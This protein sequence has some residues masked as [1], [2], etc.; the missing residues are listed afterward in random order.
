MGSFAELSTAFWRPGPAELLA[1]YAERYRAAMPTMHEAG[2]MTAIS[3]SGFMFP[4]FG[5][6][7]SVR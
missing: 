5:G 4:W 3:V 6:D 7:E 2:M 1:P